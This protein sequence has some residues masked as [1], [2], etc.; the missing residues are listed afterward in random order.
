MK[1][2]LLRSLKIVLIAIPTLLLVLFLLPILFPGKV[3]EKVKGFA[4]NN[5]NGEVNFSTV[6]LS[7]F[8]HFPSLTVT[9]HDFSL[10]GS[11]PFKK[12][13][14]VAADE[15]ALGINVRAL[16]F[17]GRIHIDKIFISD[18]LMN[19]QVNEKGE[20]NYNCLLYTSDAADE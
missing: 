9:L 10:K 8:N 7:F 4:N 3:V 18:A 1:K 6:R 12:D 14:L 17:D 19:V 11:A 20:A 16:V 2:V 13:T 5:L 15:I